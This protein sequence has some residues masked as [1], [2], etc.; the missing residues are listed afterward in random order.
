MNKLENRYEIV[1]VNT[2]ESKSIKQATDLEVSE[3]LTALA[4][5]RK[6][7]E[8]QEEFIKD[9]VKKFRIKLESDSRETVF[10]NHKVVLSNRY[11]FDKDTFEKNASKE[12]LGLYQEWRLVEQKY[13]KVLEILTFK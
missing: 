4:F 9:Y 8:K 13:M 6:G 3:Q 7:L 11:M 12:E 2:G 10:G 1:N 5:K